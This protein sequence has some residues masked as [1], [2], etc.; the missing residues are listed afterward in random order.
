MGLNSIALGIDLGTSKVAVLILEG[1]SDKILAAAVLPTSA[2]VQAAP[3][4]AEQDSNLIFKA[5]DQCILKLRPD[6]R[7][8]VSC[9]GVTGQMHGVIL[10]SQN[11]PAG[12]L[13]TWQDQRCL[14]DKFL[15]RLREQCG[16]YGLRS[17]YGLATLAWL[18]KQ[19]A[20][21]LRRCRFA[22]TI[23]DFLVWRLCALEKPVTDA[24]NAAGWGF[25]DLAAGQ[26]Q[27]DKI[28]QAKI[29]PAL[30]PEIKESGAVAG[31]LAPGCAKQWGL[32]AE[33]PVF[34]ALGDNQASLLGTLEQ[35]LKE[36]ALTLGT[37][38]QL[39][40]VLPKLPDNHASLPPTLEIR[41]Y[42]DGGFI[43]VAASLCG[44]CALDWLADSILRWCHELELKAPVREGLFK[45]LD[46]LALKHH[47][48]PLKVLSNFAGERY[49][50][51]L[52]GSI[53]GIDLHNFSLGNLA[54]ALPVSVIKTL[55]S[56]MP[57]EFMRGRTRLVGSG[58]A[59]RELRSLQNAA[60]T[61]FQL[62]LKICAQR[63][64]AAYGAARLALIK[65]QE[66][67]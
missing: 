13:I 14:K 20:P 59:L 43:A 41:P 48:S 52:R 40:A 50:P 53:Q 63:E 3:G 33:I 22:A 57:Q 35:P 11:G 64:E 10:F 44:G 28:K 23:A 49:S 67:D 29:T 32:S 25:Y 8:G 46:E 51:A 18:A 24:T 19:R 30:L 60:E 16:D 17:G 1:R 9:I 55:H 21:E 61:I 6:A 2:N 66:T 12:H 37:G 42:L 56:M 58:R 5:L 4:W 38:G 15:E 45:K 31:G 65:S 27:P 62:P 54:A 39:S 34:A 36:L 7:A 26:W 47:P